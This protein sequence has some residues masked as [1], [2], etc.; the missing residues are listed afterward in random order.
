MKTLAMNLLFALVSESF[1]AYEKEVGITFGVILIFQSHGV[2]LC[3]KPH[4]HCLISAGGV[5]EENRWVNERSVKYSRIPEGV[6][7]SLEKGLVLKN[8][9]EISES[10]ICLVE[11]YKE[12]SWRYNVTSHKSAGTIVDYLSRK[13]CG[14]LLNPQTEIEDEEGRIV[15]HQLHGGKEVRTSLSVDDFYERY[16]NHVPE[17]SA[18]VIRSYG[19][20]STRKKELLV[21]LMKRMMEEGEYNE[22]KKEEVVVEIC[23]VCEYPLEIIEKFTYE[24][25]PLML[26]LYQIQNKTPPEHEM[27]LKV[28]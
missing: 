24:K 17:E 7:E 1:K 2:G 10:G 3:Y 12:K 25:Q 6:V 19:L 28:S 14:L 8:H 13:M 23:P 4:I 15:L 5:D 18:V 20:Y 16:F 26:R 22:K 21:K 9:P 11:S 27:S